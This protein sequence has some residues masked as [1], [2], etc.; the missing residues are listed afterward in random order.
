MTGIRFLL[1]LLLAAAA[2]APPAHAHSPTQA[3][4]EVAFEQKVGEATPADLVF[5]DANGGK[6]R[7]GDLTD[8]KPLVLVLAWYG[9]ENLC[10][11]SLTTLAGRL[12]DLKFAPGEEFRIAAVSIDPHEGPADAQRIRKHVLAE[13]PAGKREGWSFLT[14]DKNAIHR[15]ADA[16]GFRYA[17]DDEAAQYAHPA[18]LVV[19]GAGGEIARYLFGLEFAARDLKLALTEA[20]NGE[21]GSVIDQIALRCHSFDP[22]TGQYGFAVMTALR[23]AGIGSAGVL[24]SVI[25]GW[26]WRERRQRKRHGKARRPEVPHG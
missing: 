25:G 21:V 16:V 1:P 3:Q 4:D 12:G 20:G 8:G 17:W 11:V 2:V 14:G 9:C 24:F 22:N 13:A 26:W 6:V 15:L 5:R 19:L 18:G 7:F 23:V 10:P